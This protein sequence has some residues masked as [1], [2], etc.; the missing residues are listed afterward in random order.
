MSRE[1]AQETQKGQ[2][3]LLWGA[4]WGR[5]L[6]LALALAMHGVRDSVDRQV[7]DLPT[8]R[9]NEVGALADKLAKFGWPILRYLCYL[10]FKFESTLLH[11]ST[12]RLRRIGFETLPAF[13][14]PAASNTADIDAKLW[15]SRISGGAHSRVH[16]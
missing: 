11:G 5:P 3:F 12:G 16:G 2:Q 1:K 15:R 14:R 6:A 10:L 9:Q 13:Q 4:A 7:G 8:L